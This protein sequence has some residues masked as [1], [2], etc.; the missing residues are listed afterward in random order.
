MRARNL[1]SARRAL[2]GLASA[3]TVSVAI[4]ALFTVGAGAADPANVYCKDFVYDLSFDFAGPTASGVATATC[5]HAATR[6]EQSVQFALTGGVEFYEP[7]CTR[8]FIGTLSGGSAMGLDGADIS[9]GFDAPRKIPFSLQD[10]HN[11]ASEVALGTGQRGA[12]TGQ[13]KFGSNGGV[14]DACQ[15]EEYNEV[16]GAT[17]QVALLAPADVGDPV[18]VALKVLLGEGAT[19]QPEPT[20]QATDPGQSEGPASSPDDKLECGE[21]HYVTAYPLWSGDTGQVPAV[22]TPRA[23]LA[24]FLALPITGFDD[25]S[26]SDFTISRRRGDTVRFLAREER[27]TSA[28]Q[29]VGTTVAGADVTTEPGTIWHVSAIAACTA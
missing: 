21:N 15:E 29:A 8:I 11:H 9:I 16:H 27:G 13:Y 7:N 14:N 17:G 23:A 6:S 22:N 20:P 1:K 26:A 28:R 18:E 2:I 12:G 4:V 3:V 10:K 25:L 24:R 19:P 5:T